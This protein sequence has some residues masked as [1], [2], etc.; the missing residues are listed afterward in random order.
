M[1]LFGRILRFIEKFGLFREFYNFLAR[2]DCAGVA[3]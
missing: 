3:V 1:P 2:D